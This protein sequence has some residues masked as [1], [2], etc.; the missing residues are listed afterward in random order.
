[1]AECVAL[2]RQ[3]GADVA[4]R[5]GIPVY[6]YER[7]ATSPARRKLEDIRRGQFEGL[8]ARMAAGSEW[9]PDF[10]PP[11]PHPTAGATAIGARPLLV[12]YNVNLASDRLE[13]ARAVASAVRERDGGLPAVKAMGVPLESRGIVQVSMNL[14]DYAR[15]SMRAAFEA[16]SRECARRGVAVLDSEIVGLVPLAAL[17]DGNPADLRIRG[18]SDDLILE[19]RLARAAPWI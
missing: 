9:T 1:M 18:F 7:A 2:A 19:H 8:A 11:A 13:V 12:A 4:S 3:T 5:F 10:G 15:T 16:V 6:L 14:T 17:S